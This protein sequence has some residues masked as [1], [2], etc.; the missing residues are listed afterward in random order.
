M[1]K[2]FIVPAGVHP[3]KTYSHA[4]RAGNTIYLAGNVGRKIDGSIVSADL[5]AQTEQAFLNMQ[6]TLQAAGATLKDVVKLTIHLTDIAGMT[7][8]ADIRSRFFS[9]PMPAS[10]AVQ[11]AALAP[12]ILLEIDGIAVLDA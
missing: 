9:A 4:V 7:T 10:T 6:S 2:E 1:K 8:V 3:A 12:G 5:A 11:V